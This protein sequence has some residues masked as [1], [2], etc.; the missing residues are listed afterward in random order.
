[1]DPGYP[2]TVND[3]DFARFVLQ[4]GS[5][6]LGPERAVEQPSPQMA[7][8]DFAYLLERIPGAMVAL[9][10]CP[11]GFAEGEAPNN[12]SNR[13]LLSEEAMV[14]GMALHAAVALAYLKR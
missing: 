12:H 11:D 4:V 8:E 7:G 14:A 10:T 9:G 2:V 6:V 1:M 13:N 5:D 3:A